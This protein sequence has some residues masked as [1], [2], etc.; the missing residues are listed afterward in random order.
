M[1]KYE[2]LTILSVCACFFSLI[3]TII[4]AFALIKVLA[5]EKST[6]SVHFV[7]A[8]MQPEKNWA[9]S[10]K[11]IEDINKEVKEDNDFYGM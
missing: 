11:T 4:G 10:E 2:I 5:I 3:S 9:T 8:E 7:P 6:H 1:T